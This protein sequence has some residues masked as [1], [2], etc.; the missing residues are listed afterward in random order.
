MKFLKA[1]QT[2]RLYLLLGLALLACGGWL[3]ATISQ[4]EQVKVADTCIRCH[5]SVYNQGLATPTIH[6]PFWERQCDLCHLASGSQWAETTLAILETEQITGT[7]VT[8]KLLWRKPQMFSS[9]PDATF[10]HL[11]GLSGL[12]A[13]AAYRIRIQLQSSSTASGEN[14]LD[15]QWIGLRPSELSEN[16]TMPLNIDTLIPV[17]QAGLVTTASLYRDGETVFVALQTSQLMTAQVEVQDLDGLS[18]NSDESSSTESQSVSAQEQHPPMR[19]LEDLAINVCYQCH[20]E[21]DLGT[22]H[23]VRLYGGKNVQIPDELPTVDGMLTCVTCHN[24]HGSE[25]EM[26]VREIIKTKLCVTCHYKFKNSSPS[27]MF[28]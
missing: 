12:T 24:P 21:A 8:Q 18:L 27:T 25:G 4:S 7:V 13:G 19:S 6:A 5:I 20:S 11:V 26:L 9:Q 3:F 10:D 1:V 28:Q 17:A 22:S 16:T 2:G 23:P 15:G 14:I